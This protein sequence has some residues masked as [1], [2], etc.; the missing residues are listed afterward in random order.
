MTEYFNETAEYAT[1]KLADDPN[2]CIYDYLKSKGIV[3]F[4]EP[5]RSSHLTQVADQ[6]I[7]SIFK[8]CFKSMLIAQMGEANAAQMIR[9]LKDTY[10]AFCEGDAKTKILSAISRA[11]VF[12]AP[13]EVVVKIYNLPRG[14]S[15][16]DV[17]QHLSGLQVENTAVEDMKQQEIETVL[18]SV[19]VRCLVGHAIRILTPN[20]D[21]TRG[22][23]TKERLQQVL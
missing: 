3:V 19:P 8:S 7:C 15:K 14:S 18:N 10:F 20:T 6:G 11:C 5:A 17:E 12:K 9:A 21:N 22:K 16:A 23:Y 2:Y 1:A 13:H 4:V